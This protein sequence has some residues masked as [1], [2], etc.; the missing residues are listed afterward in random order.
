[1][2]PSRQS[3]SFLLVSA[4]P[5][6]RMGIQ[7][8]LFLTGPRDINGRMLDNDMLSSLRSGCLRTLGA[9]ITR[10]QKRLGNHIIL[11]RGGS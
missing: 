10:K 11:S 5:A 9:E 4:I 3:V 2:H 1:M 8:N 6:H 7:G